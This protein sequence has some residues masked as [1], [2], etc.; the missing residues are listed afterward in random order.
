MEE[1]VSTGASI[2]ALADHQWP[3]L[4]VQKLN[5]CLFGVT[6]KFHNQYKE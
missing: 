4:F 6:E 5:R 2:L 3:R 1:E